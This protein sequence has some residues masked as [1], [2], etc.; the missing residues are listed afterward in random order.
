MI[1]HI[2]KEHFLAAAKGGVVAVIMA[3]L[4]VLM[5]RFKPETTSF[6]STQY[7]LFQCGVDSFHDD[8]RVYAC[9]KARDCQG[10]REVSKTPI[11]CTRLDRDGFTSLRACAR[12]A[13]KITLDLA[14]DAQVICFQTTSAVDPQAQPVLSI[15]K[16]G[17]GK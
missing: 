4:A 16:F 6:S 8:D 9:P 14:Q 13:S 17:A 10:L 2:T 15:H 7:S 1:I 5:I 3:V 12:G 11:L